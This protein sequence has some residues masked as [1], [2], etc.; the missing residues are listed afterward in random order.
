MKKRPYRLK[1][2]FYQSV[3]KTDH[4]KP[5]VDTDKY[6]KFFRTIAR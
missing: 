6:T 2:Q 3:L 5:S 4:K 1:I